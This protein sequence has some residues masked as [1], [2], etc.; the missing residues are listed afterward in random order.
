MRVIKLNKCDA[1]GHIVQNVKNTLVPNILF[2]IPDIT[3]V[4]YKEDAPIS[5]ARYDA[6]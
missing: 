2:D 3:G 6:S 5:A 4:Y 1:S